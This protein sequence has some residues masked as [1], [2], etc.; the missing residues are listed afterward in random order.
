M[1]EG[2]IQRRHRKIRFTG[3][4]V[5]AG[6]VVCE[7]LGQREKFYPQFLYILEAWYPFI[8]GVEPIT[9]PVRVVSQFLLGKDYG[10]VHNTLGNISI[11]H[12]VLSSFVRKR[13]EQVKDWAKQRIARLD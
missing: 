11:A 4:V 1:S 9:K 8:N 6:L 7:I 13:E 5:G 10:Q 12:I 3:I 2:L